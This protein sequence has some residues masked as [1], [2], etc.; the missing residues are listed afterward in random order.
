MVNESD[1]QESTVQRQDKQE[2]NKR[3]G[4]K[5]EGG[6][7]L[8]KVREIGGIEDDW[9]PGAQSDRGEFR[10]VPEKDCFY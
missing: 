1:S 2:E 5:R 6:T 3:T 9:D 7:L 8:V 10:I 4:D